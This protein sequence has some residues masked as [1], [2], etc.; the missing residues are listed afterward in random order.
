VR[1][2]EHRSRHRPQQCAVDQQFRQQQGRG[3][4]QVD[5]DDQPATIP[6]SLETVLML[7]AVPALASGIFSLELAMPS[8]P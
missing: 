4:D 7:R 3:H 6:A 8:P 1:S 2:K 5:A